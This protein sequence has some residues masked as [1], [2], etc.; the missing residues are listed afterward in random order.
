MN[1]INK[2]FIGSFFHPV[3]Q[4]DGNYNYPTTQVNNYENIKLT[5][6]QMEE[7]NQYL[8][9]QYQEFEKKQSEYELYL[10]NQMLDIEQGNEL[11]LEGQGKFDKN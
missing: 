5:P 6:E 9:N 2:G 10:K 8:Y 11:F 3:I 1:K 4:L 7:Y